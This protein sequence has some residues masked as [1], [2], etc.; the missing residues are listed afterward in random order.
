MLPKVVEVHHWK[1]NP[2][3]TLGTPTCKHF[4]PKKLL[5]H[6]QSPTVYQRGMR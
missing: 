6:V 3:Q 4:E 5:T 1:K 2:K